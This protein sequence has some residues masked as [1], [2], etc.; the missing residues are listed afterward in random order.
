[1]HDQHTS[2]LQAIEDDLQTNL[3][4][5]NRRFATLEEEQQVQQRHHDKLQEDANQ[6]ATHIQSLTDNLEEQQKQLLKYV[7]KQNKINQ[8]TNRDVIQLKKTQ[9]SH[10][11]MLST[12]QTLVLSLQSKQPAT[13]QSHQR[14]RK[15]R[16]PKTP[17]QNH[18]D[19][20][21]EEK[22]HENELHQL[23]AIT[24]LQNAS[25]EQ[26]VSSSRTPWTKVLSKK[27]FRHGTILVQMTTSDRTRLL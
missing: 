1:L 24:T 3:S 16:R 9:A 22:D 14:I 25:I 15:K 23:H 20:E 27:N 5:F 8:H 7:E 11:T 17:E 2:R 26:L 12:L 4:T 21:S 6:N 13:P 18:H 10:Q 19:S